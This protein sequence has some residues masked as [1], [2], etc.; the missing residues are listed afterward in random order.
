MPLLPRTHLFEFNDRDWVPESLRDTIV[1]TLSR[2]LDWGGFLRPLV[3]VVDDFLSAAGTREVLDLCAG[4]GG[5]AVILSQEAER[6]GLSS[7]RFLITD[8]FPR[9]PIWTQAKEQRLNNIDFI[10][11]PVDATRIPPSLSEGRARIIVNALHHFQPELAGAILRDAV[12]NQAPIFISESF[13]RDPT[14]ALPLLQRHCSRLATGLPRPLGP[15]SAR[16]ASPQEHGMRSSAPCASTPSE[17]YAISWRHLVRATNG[18]TEPTTTHFEGA[19]AT[20]RVFR[21]RF[22]PFCPKNRGT[23]NG[24]FLRS[25]SDLS[26]RPVGAEW[27]R[28]R[29]TP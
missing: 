23:A 1:E 14:G 6:L 22:G 10:A 16:S 8:L 13:E 11:E 2:S 25:R 12:D 15:G 4:A 5:P 9:V 19:D 26:I 20:F 17:T 27:T 18:P 21:R 24:R 29:Q 7:P 3:P 28:N